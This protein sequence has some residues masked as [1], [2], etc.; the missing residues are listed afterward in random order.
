MATDVGKIVIKFLTQFFTQ[1]VDYDFTAHLEDDL[2]AVARGERLWI[3]VLENF[4]T[5]FI[6]LIQTTEENVKRADVTH[7]AMEEA[8]PKCEKP[9]S[10]R[11]GKR[12][13][14]I[15]CTGYP[16]CAY[17]RNLE[18][19][20]EES[21]IEPVVTVIEG[22][23]CP[24]CQGDLVMKRGRYGQFIG[25]SQYPACKHMESLDQA[26]STQV[27]CPSCHKGNLIKKKSRFGT[28]F[29]PC[30]EYPEC[31]YALR[32]EPVPE[33]CP[34]CQWPILMSKV[35]KRWGTQKACPQ[36][37]CGYIE[38]TSCQGSA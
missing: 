15:G 7:E 37:E 30:T 10:I 19:S 9:L 38:S 26:I 21:L 8:C 34:K 11:L 13:R 12:G 25:C 29:Y 14:F 22:R 3:P 4:W 16:E 20:R 1:Y 6:N 2:D 23:Q 17:T 33:A 18:Q 36:K 32:F 28:F 5:P 27:A 35:T 24:K 31:R